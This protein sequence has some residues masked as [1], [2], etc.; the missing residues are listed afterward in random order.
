VLYEWA[1]RRGVPLKLTS[2]LVPFH[3]R[4]L[5]VLEVG[6]TLRV[7]YPLSRGREEWKTLTTAIAPGPAQVT[8]VAWSASE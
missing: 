4:A 3:R 6:L 8:P 2:P 7:E 5:P 1:R